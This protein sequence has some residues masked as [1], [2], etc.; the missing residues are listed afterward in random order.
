MV[1]MPNNIARQKESWIVL[2]LSLLVVGLYGQMLG[3]S[4]VAFDDQAYVTQNYR[5]RHGITWDNLVWVWTSFHA[6]FWH[7]LTS[8]SLMWDCQVYGLNPAG[9]H[10]SGLFLHLANTVLLFFVLRAMTGSYWRSAF[11]ACLFGIHPLHVESVAW[12]SARKDTLSTLF[13]LLAMGA[14]AR[15]AR[16]VGSVKH[17]FWTI[18]LTLLGFMAKP[19]LVTLPF[20]LLLLDYWPLARWRTRQDL[21]AL[22]REKIPLFV[23]SAV[24]AW[25][26]VLAQQKGRALASLEELPLWLRMGNAL[27][28]YLWYGF[29]MFWPSGLAVFYPRPGF[30]FPLWKPVVAA[31]V[32]SGI[33]WLVFRQ[34]EQRRY[35]VVG[36]LWYLGTLVPLLGLVSVGNFG[37]AD[38]YTYVPLL[39]L[40]LML[41]WGAVDAA[42]SWRVAKVWLWVAAVAGLVVLM[43]V[44]FMQVG[45]WKNSRTLF[46]HARD[47][48]ENNWIACHGIGLALEQEG[49]FPEAREQ[50]LRALQIRPDFDRARNNLGNL[51]VREG[52]IA[53][54]I[55]HYKDVLRN[56]PRDPDVLTNLGIALDKLGKTQEAMDIYAQALRADPD[57]VDAHVNFGFAL[58]RKGDRSSA[59]IHYRSALELC[60]ENADAHNNL[61]NALLEE[62]DVSGAWQEYSA[63]LTTEPRHADA[64]YNAAGI[65]AGWGRLEEAAQYYESVLQIT[66]D[67]A[68]AHANLGLVLAK[69]GNL[70]SAIGHF[71]QA[72]RCS[73]NHAQAQKAM[74]QY[75]KD[76]RK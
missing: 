46:E 53:E 31:I 69:Q 10:F 52:K 54:A 30:D 61:G 64:L 4:F 24:F 11:V 8:L 35:L 12:V 47:V 65:L 43:P 34:R 45:Y 60:P 15:Y 40:F 25:I 50:Y 74:D 17:Y 39:G 14:Y 62:G 20:V 32:L 73:P 36:W 58:A 38:R 49:K 41:A 7:P 48:T 18:F 42:A 75:G 27:W 70:K 63:A 44:T 72:L 76:V 13:W 29:K 6:H 26:A 16:D 57:C 33:T 55:L 22:L 51:A 59:M 67:D 5:I 1:Q 19:M 2:L 28:A 66:P 9:H 3:H 56:K 68:D 37:M 71:S 21:P 23:F